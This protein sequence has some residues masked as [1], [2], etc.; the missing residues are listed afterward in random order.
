MRFAA[1]IRG[2][3]R[4]ARLVADELRSVEVLMDRVEHLINLS[5]QDDL[6]CAAK[7]REARQVLARLRDS[8]AARLRFLEYCT[9][10]VRS[11][12]A[13]DRLLLDD[14]AQKLMRVQIVR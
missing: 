11:M 4:H 14:I 13:D 3:E 12:V 9:E 5:D 8:T 2:L 7:L 6:E 1:S 10:E